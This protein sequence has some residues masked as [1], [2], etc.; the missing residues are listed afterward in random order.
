V[1]TLEYEKFFL[2]SVYSPSSGM[3]LERLAFRTLEFDRAFKNHV[4]DLSSIKPVIIFG[5]MNVAHN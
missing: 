5:D 4:K 1:I 3:E 2:I